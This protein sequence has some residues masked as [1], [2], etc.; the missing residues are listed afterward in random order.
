MKGTIFA[1]LLLACVGCT[2]QEL[3]QWG[4]LT[5]ETREETNDALL[6]KAKKKKKKALKKLKEI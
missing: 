1:L 2:T 6:D 5:E 3:R 4:E